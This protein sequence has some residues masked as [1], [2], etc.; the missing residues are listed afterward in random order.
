[1][2]PPRC[3]ITELNLPGISGMQLLR[4]LAEERV[5]MPV[6]VLATD[7]DVPTAVECM[8]LG[9]DHFMQKPVVGPDLARLIRRLTR[10]DGR[11][12][13]GAGGKRKSSGS[14]TPT[15]SSWTS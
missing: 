12:R 15:P 4:R 9:A 10:P 5:R 7:A 14:A 11:M 3:L 2:A 6:V 8:R 13:P 1:M